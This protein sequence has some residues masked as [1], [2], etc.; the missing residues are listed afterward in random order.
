MTRDQANAT[1]KQFEAIGGF[2]QVE[3][4]EFGWMSG[5]FEVHLRIINPR[6]GNRTLEIVKTPVG[7]KEARLIAK[8]AR[9][10]AT[11]RDKETLKLMRAEREL[12]RS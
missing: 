10:K 6:T 4:H 9:G 8:Q 12:D 2:S 7:D 11:E 3:T 1:A 5:K